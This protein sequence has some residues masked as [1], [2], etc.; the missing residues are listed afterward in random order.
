MSGMAGQKIDRSGLRE[1]AGLTD[2]RWV[3]S[4]K[5]KNK[6]LE[7]FDSQRCGANVSKNARWALFRNNFTLKG[8]GHTI[9]S[10]IP[11]ANWSLLG[12]IGSGIST[13][14]GM[15]RHRV[16]YGANPPK[17]IKV[18]MT[19]VANAGWKRPRDGTLKEAKDNL[20]Y[21]SAMEYA[22]QAHRCKSMIK[23]GKTP[24]FLRSD[25]P[26]HDN[27]SDIEK[28]LSDQQKWNYVPLSANAKGD[29]AKVFANLPDTIKDRLDETGTFYDNQT[30]NV[31]S[32]LYD[33]VSKEVVISHGGT[34]AGP[35]KLHGAQI[36]GNVSNMVAGA[37]P[38][39]RVASWFGA[40]SQLR[41]PDVTFTHNRPPPSVYQSIAFS[42]LVRDAAARAGVEAVDVGHSRG[43]L[44][45]QAAALANDG[46]GVCSNS[47]PMGPAV[48]RLVGMHV[49]QRKLEGTQITHLSHK[50]DFLSTQTGLRRAGQVWRAV[51]GYPT[52]AN[53][54]D[55]L[56]FPGRFG[57]GNVGHANAFRQM[58]K[59]IGDLNKDVE[60]KKQQNNEIVEATHNLAVD[61]RRMMLWDIMPESK[62]RSLDDA[63]RENASKI[64][65]FEH[66]QLPV[67]D[68][69][70]LQRASSGQ[71]L[72]E[73]EKQYLREYVSARVARAIETWKVAYDSDD[74][75]KINVG[76]GASS[77]TQRVTPEVMEAR[78][79]LREEVRTL[80]D[81]QTGDKSK[82]AK[83]IRRLAGTARDASLSLS[84][85]EHDLVHETIGGKDDFLDQ[86]QMD[87][88]Q[89]MR[90]MLTGIV[91]A[92]LKASS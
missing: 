48:Q 37:D 36:S 18:P 62:D 12:L 35:K 46:R 6:H 78:K 40:A 51:T 53:A 44:M 92:A 90:D 57:P 30:G 25:S 11:S 64:L 60:K 13:V 91:G 75:P 56:S 34:G 82:L 26:D 65:K 15:V 49:N 16:Q 83:A 77:R 39:L 9:A 8:L 4:E 80:V 67:R 84:P 17:R 66:I 50:H 2:R 72:S 5:Q 74:L 23:D 33:E 7:W 73:Q 79:S 29:A 38:A 52:P 41:V 61:L 3:L 89:I 71:S 21:T 42:A 85:A 43:G 70:L 22:Y 58:Q 55:F 81:L 69:E 47:E 59:A 87:Q 28:G 45:A 32:V 1:V 24:Y 54:G 88:L 20:K 76:R 63:L 31:I 68:R 27:D 19:S 14:A 10:L 86:L